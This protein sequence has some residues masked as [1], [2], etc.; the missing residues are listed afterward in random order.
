MVCASDSG[1]CS[2]SPPLRP[3]LRPCALL[4][5]RPLLALLLAGLAF[6][7]LAGCSTKAS[8]QAPELPPRHWLEDNPGVP[9]E[10]KLG[11]CGD[12]AAAYITE[13]MTVR[14]MHDLAKEL[15]K[16]NSGL[17]FAGIRD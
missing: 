1:W 13:P 10:K 9:V 15:R 4:W 16:T 14:D 8:L 7:A 17:F 3:S 5:P 11:P 2:A 12:K 6:W